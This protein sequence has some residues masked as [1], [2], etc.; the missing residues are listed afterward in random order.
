[1]NT[2]TRQIVLDT[3]TTGR[4][5][6]DG[7]RVIE[8]G[9]VELINRRFTG[10]N[11]QQY[12]NPERAS[13][14]GALAVHGLKETFL[15]KHPLFKTVVEAFLEYVKGAQLIIHNAVF[16]LSFLDYE[17]KLAGKKYGK[18]A[19]YCTVIDTLPLARQMHPG[20]RNSLDALC[21]RYSVDNT[22]RERHGALLDA[23]LLALVYLAM[24]GGQTS[25]FAEETALGTTTQQIQLKQSDQKR[26]PL[27]V[28]PANEN[29]LNAHQACLVALDK[30]SNGKCIWK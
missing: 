7:N 23:E 5:I 20:Q 10:K 26:A 11:Y 30:V 8:I 1:M 29:E 19:D 25:L 17:L 4:E 6:A 14:A 13:E 27:R 9:C 28:I 21:K 12:I 24:T 16:D 2:T 18:M 22:H 15:I 3:E